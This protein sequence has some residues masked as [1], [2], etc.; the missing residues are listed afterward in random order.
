MFAAIFK[1]IKRGIYLFVVLSI[2]SV[3]L[4]RF[5]PVP[6]TPLMLIRS[7]EYLIEGNPL[8]LKY[9]WISEESISDNLK[10]A[11]V[12]AEDQKFYLHHGF[13]IEAIKKAAKNNEKGKKIKGGSTISQQCA[14]NVFLWQGR[15]WLRKGLEVYFTVLIELF[16]SKERIIEVYLNVIEMGIG[17]YGAEAASE[18]YFKKSASALT[19]S[20]AA[21]LAS[22]LPNPRKWNVKNPSGYIQKRQRWILRQMRNL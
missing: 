15:N 9:K 19:K 12:A 5:L 13:D 20:E 21:L 8:I 7:G 10:K 1:I 3:I 18:Y 11:V 14:K 17:V 2:L 22:I 6:I 16:W 4:F